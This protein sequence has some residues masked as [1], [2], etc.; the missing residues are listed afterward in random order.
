MH[1][2][3]SDSL[4]KMLSIFKVFHAKE[5]TTEQTV[6]KDMAKP[7][8]RSPEGCDCLLISR[9]LFTLQNANKGSYERRRKGFIMLSNHIRS[10]SGALIK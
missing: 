10:M 2:L 9:L 1:A 4:N 3:M 8:V 6:A 7:L 5:R